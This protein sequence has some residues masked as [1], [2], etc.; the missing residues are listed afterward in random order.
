MHRRGQSGHSIPICGGKGMS[1]LLDL[2]FFIFSLT[3]R[4]PL[5]KQPMVVGDKTDA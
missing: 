4:P 3:L 1:T 2:G 5:C